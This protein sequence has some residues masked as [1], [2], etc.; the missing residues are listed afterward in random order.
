MDE[1][2]QS[3]PELRIE[4]RSSVYLTEIVK[5]SRFLSIVGFMFL[6]IGGIIVVIAGVAITMGSGTSTFR[7]GN[8]ASHPSQYAGVINIVLLIGMLVL[9][10][11]PC[12]YLY[13]FSQQ[14][15]MGLMAQNQRATDNAF[16]NLKSCFK[17]IGVSTI[18]LL[19]LYVLA[20]ILGFLFR[21]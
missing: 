20:F 21:M 10:F 4:D 19:S 15:K 12:L 8:E 13:R 6:G 14:M 1:L 3:G 7:I 11:F 5:W 9:Y 16:E 2:S 17:F 18:V